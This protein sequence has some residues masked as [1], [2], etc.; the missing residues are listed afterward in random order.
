MVYGGDTRATLFIARG[1][2]IIA[3]GTARRP[4]VMTSAQK[5]GSRAQR[6]WGS[7][8]VFGR[9]PINEPGGQ[10]YL[11]GMPSSARV[12]VRRHRRP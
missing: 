11:E 7:L 6:D 10:A 2:K 4:I 5:V 1:A 3:D 9:A 8:V 12:P